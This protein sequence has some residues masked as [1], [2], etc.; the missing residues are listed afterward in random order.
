[1][2]Q[3]WKCAK[4]SKATIP[5]DIEILFSINRNQFFLK[6]LLCGGL[7]KLYVKFSWILMIH[8]YISLKM[9][10]NT[11]AYIYV[12]SPDLNKDP[13]NNYLNHFF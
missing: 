12:F 10:S 4:M 1:M 11:L 2:Y 3:F 6:L 9:I 7:C 5:P 8:Y 13:G